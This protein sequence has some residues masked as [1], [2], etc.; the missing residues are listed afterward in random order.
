MHV[1]SGSALLQ[2][3]LVVWWHHDADESAR[4][5]CPQIRHPA[6]SHV[7]ILQTILRLF[8]AISVRLFF[9]IVVASTIAPP[10]WVRG[11]VECA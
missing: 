7:R 3:T 5:N 10:L 4:I 1:C 8:I 2:G 11:A 6:A 9:G